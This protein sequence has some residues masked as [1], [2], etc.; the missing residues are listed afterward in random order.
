VDRWI[1]RGCPHERKGKGYVFFF[2]QVKAWRK[3]YQRSL[4]KEDPDYQ[5]AKLKHKQEQ[6]RAL[7]IANLVK[8]KKLVNAE[9][10]QKVIEHE[11]TDLKKRLYN[12]IH[13]LPPLLEDKKAADIF[14][15]LKRELDDLLTQFVGGR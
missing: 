9:Q 1:S 8:L 13:R 10:V 2:E 15:T 7:E 12:M 14:E 5:A 3:K 4:Q 6:A 11:Y